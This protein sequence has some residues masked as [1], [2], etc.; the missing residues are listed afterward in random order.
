VRRNHLRGAEIDLM[1]R[2]IG[3]SQREGWPVYLLGAK[4][5]VLA[6]FKAEALRRHAQLRV[7]GRRNG[8]FRADEEVGIPEAIRAY[9]VRLLLVGISSQMKVRF[10]AR[11]FELMGPVLAMGV[12]GSF[13]VRAGKV[14][15]APAW[16]QRA[17][18]E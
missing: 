7:A 18:L 2:L 6:A 3:L 1:G 11:T 8:Y 5:A 9:G 17:G 4:D 12:G 13:D 16:M 15:R 14:T 10:L